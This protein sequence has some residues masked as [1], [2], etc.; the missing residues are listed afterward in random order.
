MVKKKSHVNVTL[1]DKNPK[2]RIEYWPLSDCLKRRWKENAKRHDIPRLARSIQR[3]GFKDSVGF[4]R[5]LDAFAEGNGRVE[6]L[7]YLKEQGIESPRGIVSRHNEWLIP[8]T[9]GVD[10]LSIEEGKAYAVDHN[11]LVLG[12]GSFLPQDVFRL[13]D[14]GLHSIFTDPKSLPVTFEDEAVKALLLAHSAD[15]LA[16]DNGQSQPSFNGGGS[17]NV[18]T[19]GDPP[20]SHIRMVQLFLT[21]ETLPSFQSFVER[22]GRAYNMTVTTD[23]V[24]E[25]LKR[26]DAELPSK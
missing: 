3:Y 12:G 5:T 18:S 7:A 25:C 13:W 17:A 15:P 8:V 26:T 24:Y 19:N 10:A 14:E 4:D 23:V 9:V 11:N 22:L 20:A 16:A 2:L 1:E 21:V 6:A